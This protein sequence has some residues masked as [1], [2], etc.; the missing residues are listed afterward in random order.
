M[1]AECSG[2][3]GPGLEMEI[4]ASWTRTRCAGSPGL[5]GRR[6]ALWRSPALVLK[7]QTL[8]DFKVQT[9]CFLK[10]YMFQGKGLDVVIFRFRCCVFLKSRRCVLKV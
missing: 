8:C 1:R 2:S 5:Q 10:V 7:V 3:S 4:S 9:L 6:D